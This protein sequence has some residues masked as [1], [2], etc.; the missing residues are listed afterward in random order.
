MIEE[1]SKHINPR[2]WGLALQML[3]KGGQGVRGRSG[4]CK[5]LEEVFNLEVTV[6]F[7]KGDIMLLF[8]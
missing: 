5:L 4:L 1:L 7:P 8:S 3:S 2:E 6:M